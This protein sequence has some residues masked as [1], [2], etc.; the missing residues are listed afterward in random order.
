MRL[1][2]VGYELIKGVSVTYECLDV[3]EEN[4]MRLERYDI[5]NEK[6]HYMRYD[7]R[8]NRDISS[9]KTFIKDF[10]N[11]NSITLDTWGDALHCLIGRTFESRNYY[12]F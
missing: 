10:A 5:G 11:K 12:R 1:E 3:S 7:L 4:L 8:N 9:L 2:V 6:I